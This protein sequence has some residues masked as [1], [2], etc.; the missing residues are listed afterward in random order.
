M[1]EGVTFRRPKKP[2]ISIAESA[3]VQRPVSTL[4]LGV[5]LGIVIAVLVLTVLHFV[6]VFLGVG[7]V[8][9]LG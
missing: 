2:S 9:L 4:A 8:R 1:L 6:L 7:V 5:G 3:L